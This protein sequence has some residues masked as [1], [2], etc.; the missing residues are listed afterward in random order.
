LA[1][2]QPHETEALRKS[3]CYSEIQNQQLKIGTQH[4]KKPS[5]YTILASHQF[6]L[7]ASIP[8]AS[9]S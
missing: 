8:T 7:L 4:T 3:E 6:L 9:Q 5:N 2:Q 1:K